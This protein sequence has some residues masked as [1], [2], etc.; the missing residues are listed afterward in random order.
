MLLKTIPKKRSCPGRR[1]LQNYVAGAYRLAAAP[2]TAVAPALA[3]TAHWALGL[4]APARLATTEAAPATTA[5]RALG[6]AATGLAT[7]ATS[8]APA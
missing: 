2:A 7:E 1:Q 3:T 5:H 8:T 4:A 6:L